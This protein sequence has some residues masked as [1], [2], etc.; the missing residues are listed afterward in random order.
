M[1]SKDK[2]ESQELQDIKSEM[3]SMNEDIKD[4]KNKMD[5]IFYIVSKVLYEAEYIRYHMKT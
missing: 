1:S 5:N 3:K 2:S 4:I